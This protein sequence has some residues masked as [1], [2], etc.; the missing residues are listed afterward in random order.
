MNKS[1]IF[2]I[3]LGFAVMIVGAQAADQ[4]KASSSEPTV[5]GTMTLNVE[6][7]T[8][9]WIGKK[10]VGNQ[11]HGT[12]NFSKGNFSIADGKLTGGRF[13]VDMKSITDKDLDSK[14]MRAKLEGHLKSEDFFGVKS[15][16]TG[17]FSITKAVHNAKAGSDEA[18]YSITGTMKLKGISQK[19]SFPARIDIENGTLTAS[20]K[21][22]FDRSKFDVRYGSGSFF[23][24]LGD[25][26][27]SDEIS[28]NL[29]MKAT[30]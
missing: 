2:S 4:T 5:S 8:I 21:V 30:K 16:P 29:N 9:K 22:V 27:I 17:S 19:L 10:V 6:K 18:N 25:N 24:N 20:A 15:F 13:D 14:E 11:H 7:S 28:L 3:L 1:I 23:D 12:I 26:V